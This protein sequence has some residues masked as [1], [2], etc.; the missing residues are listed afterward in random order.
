M[1]ISY[2]DI[3][4]TCKDLALYEAG[5]LKDGNGESMYDSV[6]IGEQDEEAVRRFVQIGCAELSSLLRYAT[7]GVELDGDTV[8][9]RF[10]E[11]KNRNLPSANTVVHTLASMAMALWL[12]DK[13]QSRS[14]SYRAIAGNMVKA[15]KKSINRKRPIVTWKLK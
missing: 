10:I 6:I 11:E 12:E 1:D 14:E 5:R 2:T 3:M 4:E 13:S 9:L 7:D 8:C 15:V